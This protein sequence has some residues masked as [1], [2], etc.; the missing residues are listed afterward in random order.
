M[1]RAP[2]ASI[3]PPDGDSAAASDNYDEMVKEFKGTEDNDVRRRVSERLE[4]DR[5]STSTLTRYYAVRAMTKLDPRMFFDALEAAA[6]DEDS[7]VR[8]VAKRALRQAATI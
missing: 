1:S 7:T 2:R 8:A 6:D 3:A 4:A 5:R